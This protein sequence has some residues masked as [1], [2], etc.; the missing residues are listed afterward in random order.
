M[1][2]DTQIVSL[3]Y[4]YEKVAISVLKNFFGMI[5]SFEGTEQ[6][7]N[8]NIINILKGGKSNEN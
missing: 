4:P 2:S 1:L 5:F 7:S 3:D 8:M 6:T